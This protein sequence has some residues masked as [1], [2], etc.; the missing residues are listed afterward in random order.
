[1]S[2][3]SGRRVE[4]ACDNPTGGTRVGIQPR[5]CTLCHHPPYQLISYNTRLI[6]L[7]SSFATTTDNHSLQPSQRLPRLREIHLRAL[8]GSLPIVPF[9]QP[10]PADPPRRDRGQRSRTGST[11]ACS[12]VPDRSHNSHGGVSLR[13]GR[14]RVSTM[15]NSTYETALKALEKRPPFCGR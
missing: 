7:Q 11:R 8:L 6:I 12:Q 1:M 4:S 3:K 9:D 15:I 5:T 10:G 13:F 2:G 14:H